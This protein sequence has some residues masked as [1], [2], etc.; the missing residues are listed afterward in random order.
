VILDWFFGSSLQFPASDH[1]FVFVVM[2]LGA[3]LATAPAKVKLT[4]VRLEPITLSGGIPPRNPSGFE[5]GT[6]RTFELSFGLF[7]SVN[8]NNITW[9]NP[10]GGLTFVAGNKGK[11]VTVSGVSTGL[12]TLEV[13]IVGLS[14][15]KPTV[16]TNVYNKNVV[17]LHVFVVRRNDGSGAA[18]STS[19]VND[20]VARANAIFKQAAIEFQIAGA[21]QYIDNTDLLGI[22]N[23]NNWAEA[24]TLASH[25]SGTGG[26]E[27]YFVDDL[28]GDT[29]GL[30]IR[31]Q[32]V[33]AGLVLDDGAPLKTLAHEIG[34]ACNWPDIYAERNGSLL[35]ND[36]VK[37]AWLPSDWNSGPGPAYYNTGLRHRDLVAE[38]LL[39]HGHGPTS[40]E[41]AIVIPRGH[42]Y[43]IPIEGGSALLLPVGLTSMNR[44]PTHW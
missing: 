19:R 40:G 20:M 26:L 24:L 33:A 39:M 36:K 15:A 1:D 29:A 12:R 13:D 37:A 6:M 44:N 10:G 21:V 14:G 3:T 38:R 16:T 23:A 31:I 42:V 11:Q 18:T 34:H 32:G 25:A 7:S 22:S 30:H 27:V 5:A 9:S 17:N 35:P 28:Q 4:K 41:S 8:D 43:G 2:R